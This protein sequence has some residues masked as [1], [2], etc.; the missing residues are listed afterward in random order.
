M[1]ETSIRE[2]DRLRV[3]EYRAL[4][5][6]GGWSEVRA[7][8]DALQRALDATWNVTARTGTGD[9]VGMARLL[10]DGVLYASLWD[11]IVRRDHR[12]Q[13]LGTAI[14]DAIMR[15]TGDRDLM[16]LVA[17]PLGAPLYRR[18]G[19]AEQSRGSTGM[20]WRR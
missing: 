20:V 2:G 8:D 1:T 16:A 9:L 11:M 3:G 10:D 18:A 15:R 6:D 14:L 4:R 12:G 7:A 5:A 19:F 17:T 13:G